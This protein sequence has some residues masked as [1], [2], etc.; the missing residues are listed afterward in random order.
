M[1]HP[2]RN[3]RRQ[4]RELTPITKALHNAGSSPS[5]VARK[6]GVTPSTVTKVMLG[7]SRSAKIEALIEDITGKPF[8]K[9][10]TA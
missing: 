7:Q 1:V 6:A 3:G 10:R 9:L 2:K 8:D 4:E 5:A